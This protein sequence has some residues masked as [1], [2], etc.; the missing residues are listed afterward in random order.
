MIENIK[1]LISPAGN[2]YVYLEHIDKLI[3]TDE[4][5]VGIWKRDWVRLSNYKIYFRRT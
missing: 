1:F 3:I 2:E 4:G 5:Y